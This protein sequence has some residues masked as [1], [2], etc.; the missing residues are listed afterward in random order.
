M[1]KNQKNSIFTNKEI[2]KIC[3]MMCEGKK[4]KLI[5]KELGIKDKKEK[6]RYSHVIEAILN[7]DAWK[8]ISKNYDFR[9]YNENKRQVLDKKI[10]EEICKLLENNN[11]LKEINEKLNVSI[12][13]IYKIKVRKNWKNISKNYKW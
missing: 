11:S 10:V 13:V 8:S 12:H 9:K 6:S 5:I 7:K 1:L 4:P 3:K 2:H